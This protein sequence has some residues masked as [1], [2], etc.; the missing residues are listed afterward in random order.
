MKDRR[1]LFFSTIITVSFALV[2]GLALISCEPLPG[3][4]EIA[5]EAAEAPRGLE[6]NDVPPGHVDLEMPVFR[7]VVD[8]VV[9]TEAL[10][11]EVLAV[12][13]EAI[14]V[15]ALIHLHQALAALG[16]PLYLEG[17]EEQRGLPEPQPRT[18]QIDDDDELA[19]REQLEMELQQMAT[20]IEE[21]R[22]RIGQVDFSRHMTETME[23]SA[24]ILTVIV[25]EDFVGFTTEAR[26]VREAVAPIDPEV[27]VDDQAQEVL[28]FFQTSAEV[29]NA[30][31]ARTRSRL[32]P[33]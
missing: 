6:R 18:G 20:Q 27:S 26:R 1:P 29:L 3:E 28:G 19:T 15:Q 21:L 5:E 23:R 33:S 12:D 32:R 14:V 10:D 9:F 16:Q 24:E 22:G 2:S 7:E 8:Y 30:I 11:E 31:E 25:E 13:G 4:E 17:I